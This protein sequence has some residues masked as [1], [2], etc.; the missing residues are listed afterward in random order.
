[1]WFSAS[2]VHVGLFLDTQP[3]EFHVQHTGG[4]ARYPYLMTPVDGPK[5]SDHQ[6]R[7][8]CLSSQCHF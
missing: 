2:Q 1:M 8:A 7:V 4:T 5:G 6:G 3:D